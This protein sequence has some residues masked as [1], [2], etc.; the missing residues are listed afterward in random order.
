MNIVR[1]LMRGAAPALAILLVTAC[2]TADP[3]VGPAS[4]TVAADA[5]QY[6]VGD[7]WV[8]RIREGFLTPVVYEETKTV[9]AASASGAT[10][11]VTDRSERFDV[12]RTE[13]WSGPGALS[14]GALFDIE[15][16]RFAQPVDLYRFPL[17]PGSGWKQRVL[18]FNEQLDR[19]GPISRTVR[20]D[21]YERVT[22]PAGAFDAVRMT[23]YMTL[24][25]EEFWRWPTRCTYVVW[26]APAVKGV[27]RA[28]KRADYLEKGGGP[29]S[30]GTLP[31]QNALVELVSFTPGA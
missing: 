19:D 20:V 5:P 23:V 4:G 16:R 31:A 11:R 18:N 8:Y 10:M 14:Q 1:S 12:V 3:A 17:R 15:T 13:T 28:I 6:R 30:G 27:V 21:G 24:D 29:D 22:T 2:A 25:D 7:R 9:T 26:Y